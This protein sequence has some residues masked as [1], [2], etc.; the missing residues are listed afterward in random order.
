MPLSAGANRIR[1]CGLASPY[2]D[3]RNSQDV[4]SC[5]RGTF[6]PL[7]TCDPTGW[8]SELVYQHDDILSCIDM[9]NAALAANDDEEE[10]KAA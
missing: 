2:A 9:L 6:S 1:R 5:L 8:F 7:D 10:R 4:S 3:S